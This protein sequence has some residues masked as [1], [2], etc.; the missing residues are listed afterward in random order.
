MSFDLF[1]IIN[2][3]YYSNYFCNEPNA[4]KTAIPWSGSKQKD[5]IL[6][7]YKLVYIQY[8]LLHHC[9]EVGHFWGRLWFI[10]SIVNVWINLWTFF[11][12]FVSLKNESPDWTL[13]WCRSVRYFPGIHSSPWG[14]PGESLHQ[15]WMITYYYILTLKIC[16]KKLY[17]TTIIHIY[18]SLHYF[19]VRHTFTFIR[20]KI[21]KCGL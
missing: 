9:Y 10:A 12:F 7:L 20:Y 3:W 6:V 14:D 2:S 8:V 11:S 18:A 15:R 13:N 21:A 17:N 5:Y 1:L 4:H 16:F 19:I